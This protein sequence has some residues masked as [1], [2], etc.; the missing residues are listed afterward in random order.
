MLGLHELMKTKPFL[1]F[2]HCLILAFMR[3]LWDGCEKYFV[4]RMNGNICLHG[5]SRVSLFALKSPRVRAGLS[6][7]LSSALLA[8]C[9]QAGQLTQL[10]LSDPIVASRGPH[11]TIW[12]RTYNET[13]P[14]GQAI[15]KK[16]YYTEIAT[17]LNRWSAADGKFIPSS[18]E[19]EIVNGAAVAR[20][21]AHVVSL[22][23]NL[24]VAG[25]VEVTMHDGQRLRSSV[26]G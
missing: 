23:P 7:L 11:S 14:K 12:E 20:Q 18:E 24:N 17:G 15:Q 21:G 6:F 8:L 10:Q 19:F 25:S 26:A 1:Y 5:S 3:F 22:A 4:L 13:G 9:A 2:L 16:R